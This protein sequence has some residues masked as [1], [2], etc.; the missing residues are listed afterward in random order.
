MPKTY[1]LTFPMEAKFARTAFLFDQSTGEV[2]RFE[3][4]IFDFRATRSVQV[5]K[6][7]FVFKEGSPV[8]A[9]KYGNFLD[10]EQ[11]VKTNLA[12]LPRK[13]HLE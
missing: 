9:Y 13:D 10:A 3:D 7:L 12:T 8:T 4:E 11:L 5:K 6:E 1:V 2:R